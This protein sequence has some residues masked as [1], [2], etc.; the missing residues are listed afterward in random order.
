M[1]N[2]YDSRKDTEAKTLMQVIS[3]IACLC[4]EKHRTICVDP[5]SDRLVT[6]V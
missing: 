6:I 3:L 5:S 2:K 1:E 4:I